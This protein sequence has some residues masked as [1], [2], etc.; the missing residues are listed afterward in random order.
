MEHGRP[1]G[2]EVKGRRETMKEGRRRK[3][4]VSHTCRLVAAP[5]DGQK[6]INTE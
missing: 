3:K 1:V 4:N 5:L 6:T 2:V